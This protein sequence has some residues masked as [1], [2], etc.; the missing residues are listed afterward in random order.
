MPM[1]CHMSDLKNFIIRCAGINIGIHTLSTGT[2]GYCIDYLTDDSPDIQVTVTK[3]DIDRVLSTPINE[4]LRD[5]PAY[6][7]SIIVYEKIIE[8]LLDY[9]CFMVHGAAIAI[10]DRA[11]IF[12]AKSGTGK[13]THI[14]QWLRHN[15]EVYVVNGDK[16]IIR[17]IDDIPYVCGTPWYG[18]ERLGCNRMVP[19]NGIAF[20]ERDEINSISEI[21]F[22]QAYLQLLQHVHVPH[23]KEKAKKTLGLARQLD[24]KVSYYAFRINNYKDDCYS[25]AYDAMVGSK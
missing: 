15:K 18:K 17:M 24:N 11:W 1:G 7:E 13:T 16:P 2:Y 14:K 9:K 3:E 21:P 12:S 19:L 22:T 8:A 20:L 5:N 6:L 4:A 23:D 10:A 25:V